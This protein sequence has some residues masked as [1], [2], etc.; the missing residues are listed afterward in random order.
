MTAALAWT[1]AA[2]HTRYAHH[3]RNQYAGQHRTNR[4]RPRNWSPLPPAN[5]HL[6]AP[7][8]YADKALHAGPNDA[9][10]IHTAITDTLA[11][12]TA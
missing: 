7:T 2:I 10:A 9:T 12:V 8:H 5:R 4:R 6:I 11:E 1:A 3:R